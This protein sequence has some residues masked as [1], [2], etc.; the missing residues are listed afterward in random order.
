[1][2]GVLGSLLCG[3]LTCQISAVLLRLQCCQRLQL[4]DPSL[5]RLLAD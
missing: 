5:L 2:H 1:M 4:S 3:L